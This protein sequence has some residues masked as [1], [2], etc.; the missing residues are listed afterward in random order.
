MCHDV[1][2]P[3]SEDDNPTRQ[4]SLTVS[5][6]IVFVWRNV[7]FFCGKSP[8]T[9]SFELEQLTYSTMEQ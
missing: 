3:H 1:Q 4:V 9:L 5:F 7:D 6:H 2:S 8:M